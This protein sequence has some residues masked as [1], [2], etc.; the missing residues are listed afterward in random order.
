MAVNPYLISLQASHAIYLNRVGGSLASESGKYVDAIIKHAKS[1]QSK[2]PRILRT[3]SQVNAFFN[4]INALMKAEFKDWRADYMDNLLELAEGESGFQARAL[5]N[6]LQD[7]TATESAAIGARRIAQNKIVLN[8]VTTTLATEFAKMQKAQ[9]RD[10][11][12]IIYD[13][14]RSG[15]TLR[16]TVKNLTSSADRKTRRQIEALA[17]T[18]TN[19][20]AEIARDEL[21]RANDDVVIGYR[22][23]ATIDTRTTTSCKSMDQRVVKR[24]DRY[25]PKPPFHYQCRTMTT[26][27]LDGRYAQLSKHATRATNL[28]E[29]GYASSQDQYYDILKRTSAYEQ[30][31]ALGKERGDLFRNSGL[32]PAEFR[33]A[34][35]DRMGQPLTIKE[36]V[37]KDKRLLERAREQGYIN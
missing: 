24:S 37:K 26:P 9:S 17:R 32:T 6:V 11:K 29:K 28:G 16:N 15:E 5:E 34:M 4:E 35:V 25:P 18:G 10:F 36:M 22:I 19:A 21:Y 1:L 14:W 12:K 27:E 33:D 3:K 13:D 23:L 7:F 20:T 30:N 8:G 31:E 2:H